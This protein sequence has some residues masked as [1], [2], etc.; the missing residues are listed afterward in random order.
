[1]L[2]KIIDMLLRNIPNIVTTYLCLYNLCIIHDDKFD[3]NWAK[4]A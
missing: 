4:S 2:L 3:L 1:M